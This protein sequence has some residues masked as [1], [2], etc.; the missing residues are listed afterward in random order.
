MCTPAMN[1]FDLETIDKLK[2][3]KLVHLK[4]VAVSTG[5]PQYGVSHAFI[6]RYKS[7]LIYLCCMQVEKLSYRMIC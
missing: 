7:V 5:I 3:L 1:K 4:E 6:S 2:K